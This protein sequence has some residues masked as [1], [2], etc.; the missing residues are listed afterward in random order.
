MK[1]PP[2]GREGFGKNSI[3]KYLTGGAFSVGAIQ[4]TS[5]GAAHAANVSCSH[6]SKW[7][8]MLLTVQ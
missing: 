7:S 1:K 5:V 8:L 3:E 2:R 6:S 4:S